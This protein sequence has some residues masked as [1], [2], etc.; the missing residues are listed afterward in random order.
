MIKEKILIIDDDQ[1]LARIVQ[2]SLDREGYQTV[3]ATSGLEGLQEAYRVQP[4]LVILDIMMPGM[5]GWEVCRRLKETSNVPIFI[6]SAKGTETDVVK[7]FQL[8]ADDYLTKPFSVAELIAR[9]QALLRARPQSQ[10]DTLPI[11]SVGNLTIDL[12]R[13]LV[14][15]DGELVDLTPTE[16]KLLECFVTYRN[17][18][19]PHKFLLTEVWG[20]EYIDETSYLK[21]Y[22]R[23]LRQKLEEDPANPQLIVTEWDVGYRFGKELESMLAPGDETTV[24]LQKEIKRL[25]LQRLELL[26]RIEAPE[27]RELPD[28]AETFSLGDL[29]Q[30]ISGI[31]HDLRGGLGVIRNTVGFMLDDVDGDDT[32]ATDLRKIVQSAEFCEVVVRNLMALGGGEAFEPTEVNIERVVR[33]VFFM[34]ERKLVDVTLVVDADPDTPTIMADEGQMKQVFMNLIK[35]AGEAMPDGGMLTLR[36]RRKGQMLCVE[37]S[38]TGYGISPEDQERLFYKFFTTKERGYGLG[39]HIVNTIVK[40]HGGTIEVESKVGEG[41]TFTLHLPIESK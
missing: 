36:T 34:L 22:V 29:T 28:E 7:G 2:L 40:R 26:R 8:G 16:F 13:R 14:M 18:V 41:T 31:V 39:L 15:R 35:N 38:D 33:E 27:K 4:D 17:R 21:L 1:D 25:R 30:L 23:Y 24:L 32:L 10:M 19:L 6:L 20:P 11:F 37:I 3:M 12:N 5:L 9:V